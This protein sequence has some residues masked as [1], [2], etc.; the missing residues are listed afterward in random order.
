MNKLLLC[1]GLAV[2]FAQAETAPITKSL[3]HAIHAVD[4]LDTTLAF[5]RDVF[6]IKGNASDFA[7]P[8]VPLLDQRPWGDAA[9]IHALGLAGCALNLPISRVWSARPRRLS[10]PIQAQPAWC[11]TCAI[12]MPLSPRRRRRAPPL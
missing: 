9:A 4:D 3:S 2:T 6:G 11:S 1:V 10:T 7:N 12:S 5:H 8:A